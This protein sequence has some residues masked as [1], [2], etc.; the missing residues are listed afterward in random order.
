MNR[1]LWR[2]NIAVWKKLTA[3]WLLAL[4]VTSSG[5]AQ[6]AAAKRPLTHNDY[7]SWRAIQGQ[8]L[9]RDGK[10]LAYASDRAGGIMNLW[11]QQ[12]AGGDRS[13]ADD[14]GAVGDRVARQ[15]RRALRAPDLRRA[16]ADV[17]RGVRRARAGRARA[18]AR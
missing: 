11:V 8:S 1:I 14:L 10:L 6:Q 3:L 17:S 15:L 4:L 18:A 2:T 12:V 9:S 5:Y 16:G 13:V 7:D